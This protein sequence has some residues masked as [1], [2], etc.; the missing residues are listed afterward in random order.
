MWRKKLSRARVIEAP[1]VGSPHLLVQQSGNTNDGHHEGG[2]EQ[3][4]GQCGDYD[5]LLTSSLDKPSDGQQ[6]AENGEAG[7]SA[8]PKREIQLEVT[9]Q[10]VDRCVR[11]LA[12]QDEEHAGRCDNCRWHTKTEQ[13]RVEDNTA[14]E[15]H[16]SHDATQCRP[17]QEPRKLVSVEHDLTLRQLH[18]CRELE[19]LL[20]A[21]PLYLVDHHDCCKYEE[22]AE[23]KV[24]VLSTPFN[25][26]RR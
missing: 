9:P 3:Y 2:R 21:Y 20:V 4:Y 24:V 7:T 17:N 10:H 18:P 6:A 12:V 1:D 26:D 8:D 14:A 22:A 13:A 11:S 5:G 23:H 16:S 15:A 25:A 19:I